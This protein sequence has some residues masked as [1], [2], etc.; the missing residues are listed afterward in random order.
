MCSLFV[1]ALF[2]AS[3]I[4]MA[5]LFIIEHLPL[6]QELP[7]IT[8]LPIIVSNTPSRACFSNCIMKSI[9]NVTLIPLLLKVS[10]N[11]FGLS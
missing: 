4:A 8:N 6:I 11:D 2:M 5:L 3:R 9:V 1:V 10:A 7:A